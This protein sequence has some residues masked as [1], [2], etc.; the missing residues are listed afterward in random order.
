MASTAMVEGNEDVKLDI[1]GL[2]DVKL[3][4]GIFAII[5]DE[6]RALWRVSSGNLSKP[7]QR[8]RHAEEAATSEYE[9][10]STP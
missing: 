10:M 7:C 3:G 1:G 2:E 5:T 6:A 9:G 8:F 4:I